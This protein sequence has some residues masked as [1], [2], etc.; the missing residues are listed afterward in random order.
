MPLKNAQSFGRWLGIVALLGGCATGPQGDQQP[1]SISASP[2]RAPLTRS[3]A[4]RA[5]R[6]SGEVRAPAA[7][8]ERDVAGNAGALGVAVGA[9]AG[10]TRGIVT[11]AAVDRVSP[12][13]LPEFPW[14]PPEP[15]ARGILP[16]GLAR[17]PDGA[18]V[19][20][21]QVADRLGDGLD[22]AGYHEKSYYAAPNGFA[23]VARL[24]RMFP[25]GRPEPDDVRF[26]PPNEREPFSLGTYLQRLFVAPPGLYRVIALVATDR[27]IANFGPALGEA[28][29]INMLRSGAISLPRTLGAVPFGQDHRIVVLVYEFR[30]GSQQVVALTPGRL[31]AHQH[32]ERTGLAASF[33]AAR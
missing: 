25:D 27:E 24:E 4:P 12:P 31:T 32:L 20:L 22:R 2:Q 7:N 29:A 8:E 16:L 5:P 19:T 13:A 33:R 18:P 15:S 21:Q 17:S 30:R 9:M 6:A 1:G 23:V 3:A 26:I 28:A 11:G 14:P 10:G